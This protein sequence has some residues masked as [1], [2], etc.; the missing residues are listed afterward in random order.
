MGVASCLGLPRLDRD[1]KIGGVIAWCRRLPKIERGVG[2]IGVSA[3]FC[4]LLIVCRNGGGKAV[5]SSLGPPTV[6]LYIRRGDVAISYGG[7]PLVDRSEGRGGDSSSFLE[8]RVVN[9][10]GGR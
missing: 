3:S 9:G 7:L 5:A 1:G 6:G 4:R 2:R 10:D 8:V